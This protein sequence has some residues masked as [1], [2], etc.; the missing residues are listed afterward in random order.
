M[1]HY[2][3]TF[4]KGSSKIAAVI[5]NDQS[6]RSALVLEAWSAADQGH[7]Q[8]TLLPLA[9]KVVCLTNFKVQSRGRSLVFFDRDL[10]VAFDK[11]TKCI[12]WRRTG[13]LLAKSYGE[14]PV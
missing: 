1:H 8:T 11:S 14:K 10:R 12:S 9:G 4:K 3:E 13:M 6:L 2:T 7:M 5:V